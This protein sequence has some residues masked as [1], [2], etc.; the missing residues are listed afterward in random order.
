MLGYRRRIERD[1][2]RW[3]ERGWVTA[4]GAAAI[5]A[6]VA[7]SGRGIN[8][9]GALGTLGAVLLAFGAMSFVAANWQEMSKLARLA[10]LFGAMWASYAAAGA[11][12]QRGLALF[13]DVA[14]LLGCGIFGAN[15]MLIAQMYHI[16]GN[17][18]DAVLVWGAGTLLAGVA[19]KSNPALALAM[20]LAALWGS[21][22]TVERNAVYWPF[23]AGWAAVTAPILWRGWRPGMH[24]SAF[25][26][27]V[28]VIGLGYLLNGGHAH[29]LVVLLGLAVAGIG[30]FAGR[31]LPALRGEEQM[32]VG[33][34]GG[35]AFAGLFALQFLDVHRIEVP[36]L[37]L[38]AAI[39]LALMLAVVAW[40]FRS[41]HRGILWL[42]YAGFSAEILAVYFKTIGTLMGSSV[43]FLT[44]GLVVIALSWFA[45]RLHRQ[46]T[47]QEARP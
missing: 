46:A 40:G 24:L 37:V 21:W 18:P 29:E 34:G 8:L 9:A 45:W 44:S 12:H 14:I 47:A 20:L 3:R 36:S 23:L 19:L 4:E 1:V 33:Y 26:L 27:S 11:L 6:E 31:A 2:D 25:A 16:E 15:I 17:P 13:A 32:L 39:T 10:L 43:F 38:F 7:Q 42:G 22:E 41:G 30:A 5:R 35:M 28:W